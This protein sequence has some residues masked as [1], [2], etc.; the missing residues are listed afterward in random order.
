[1]KMNLAAASASLVTAL[2]VVVGGA[3]AAEPEID[4]NKPPTADHRIS[5]RLLFGSDIVSSIEYMD[6]YDLDGKQDD[7]LLLVEPE[8]RAVLSYTGDDGLRAFAELQLDGRAFLS[9]GGANDDKSEAHVRVE[10]AYVD[11]TRFAGDYSLRIGRQSFEDSRSWWYDEKIDAI[12]LLWQRDTWFASA[13]AAREK[14]F[15]DD[16]AHEDTDEKKEFYILTAGY[17]ADK[18]DQATLFLIKKKDLDSRRHEDPLFVGIQRIGEMGSDLRYWLNAAAVRG[19]S[20]RRRLRAYGVDTGMAWRLD[21]PWKP[22][23]TAAL[24]Y[25][26]GDD[27]LRDGVDGNFRQTDLQDNESRTF[28]ITSFQYYGEVSD[29]ELSNLWIAHLGFGIRPADDTSIELNLFRY[30][31][32]D[33]DDDLFDTDLEIDPDGEHKALGHEI[34]FVLAHRPNKKTK[35]SL[36]LGAFLP[37]DAFPDNADPALLA[38]LKFGYRF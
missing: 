9:K 19:E 33:A 11:L 28:G 38:K 7:H 36:L 18:R 1:M 3:Y 14:A 34:D 17:Y 29:L 20:R 6:N 4:F 32:V 12:R 10:Q 23:V 22:F 31:Q 30:R 25:G 8:L 2:L 37:G 26:S 15:A 35:V 24:A 16:F 5:D 21:A 27:H 13:S